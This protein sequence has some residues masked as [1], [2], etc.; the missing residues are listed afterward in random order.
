MDIVFV[1]KIYGDEGDGEVV[2]DDGV[3]KKI[4]M[5]F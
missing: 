3:S 5:F 1:L 2:C 4:E